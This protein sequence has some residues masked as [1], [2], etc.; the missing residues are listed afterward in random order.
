MQPTPEARDHLAQVEEIFVR[1]QCERWCAASAGRDGL[2]I[3][4]DHDAARPTDASAAPAERRQAGK[5]MAQTTALKVLRVQ[6]V[7]LV[8]AGAWD[9]GPRLDRR[10]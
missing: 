9:E 6:M 10:A 1:T 3:R 8:G 7:R 5:P 4:I 2:L